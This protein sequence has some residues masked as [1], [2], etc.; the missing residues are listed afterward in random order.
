MLSAAIAT[1]LKPSQ[2]EFHKMQCAIA[3]LQE[4]TQCWLPEREDSDM[5]DIENIE[6]K[7]NSAV[8]TADASV[9]KKPRLTSRTGKVRS[10]VAKH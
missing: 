5:E 4:D 3:Q 7:S 6:E 10:K 2:E 9:P 8:A 1:A